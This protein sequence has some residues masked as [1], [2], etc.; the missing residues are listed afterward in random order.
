MEIGERVGAIESSKDGVT[1]FYGYGT[2]Q[3][4]TVP[5]EDVG[6]FNLGIPNPIILLDNGNMV[7]GCE[8]W[9]GGEKKVAAMISETEII[10]VKPKRNPP[11][12]PE[13][14]E[15]EGGRE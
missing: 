10:L 4:D 3:G 12:P 8:C 2:F 7:Y 15:G 11:Q 6:G 13:S 14:L 5:P 1:K 9:W